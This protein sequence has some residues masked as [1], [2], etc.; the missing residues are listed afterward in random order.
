M[1]NALIKAKITSQ[2]AI[3]D[4]AIAEGRGMTAEEQAK[5]DALET[6]ITNLKKTME[7][8]AKRDAREA[9]ANKPVNEPIF[10]EVKSNK[11]VWN[12]LGEQ[13][14]A[15]RNA[16]APGG[17]I[18]PRLNIRA[19]A[20]GMNEAFPSEGGFFVQ[21]DFT[22]E[23]LKNTYDISILAPKCR[24]IP[25]SAN[26]NGLKI[27]AVDETSRAN[28]SRWGG[29][30]TYWEGEADALSGS[31]PKFRQIELKLRKL[32]GLCYM[33]D[34]LMQD[35]TALEAIVSQSFSEEFAFK[36][37]DAI[38]RG[39]GAGE[40]LGILNS[41]SLITVA[42]TASQTADTI[43]LNN[44]QDMW[45]RLYGRGSA[46]AVW[47][48]NKECE[49]Q[50]NNMVLATGTYSAQTVYLP[51]TGVVG[52][53]YMSIYG[54]PVFTIEHAAAL[55]DAG[56][57]MLADF[58]QYILCDKG[59]ISTAQSLHVRFLYDENVFRF[60]YRVDGQPT[61]NSPVTPY[62]GASTATVSP[63]ITLAARA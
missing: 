61:W 5:F 33:T 7:A 46:N 1:I 49:K 26:A 42:K 9:E 8:Q 32:T 3:L 35:Q 58:S 10:A 55:G 13:L 39:D 53:A 25:I 51:P 21:T 38:I 27:N 40:P 47:L 54:R 41:P 63:F 31:K 36:V 16:A 60:I 24:K 14:L 6:E 59:G 29:V 11:P 45:A 12:S 50:L 22:T 37:D 28:G 56:D 2:D 4:A 34:E 20:S 52:N 23:L 48:I 44:I 43:T 62:K 19:A 18:D 15:V 30:T 17:S 57:I